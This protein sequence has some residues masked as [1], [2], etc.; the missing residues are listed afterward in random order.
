MLRYRTGAASTPA[1]GQAMARYLASE[2]LKPEDPERAR[3]YMGERVPE[4]ASEIDRLGHAVASGT[5]LHSEAL[6]QLMRQ[7]YGRG[8][9][10]LA[11]LQGGAIRTTGRVWRGEP[12]HR[13]GSQVTRRCGAIP[14]RGWPTGWASDQLTRCT[15]PR[16]PTC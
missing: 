1:A 8:A 13:G 5:L 14:V 10:D 6:D 15:S 11:S 4:P 7:Q 2:T 12:K 16:S 9:E 3:Y